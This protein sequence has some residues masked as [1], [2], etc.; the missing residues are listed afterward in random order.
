M[1]RGFTIVELLIVIVV[2]GILAAISLVTYNGI[3]DKARDA[4][5][6]AT[7]DAYEKILLIYKAQHG[8]FPQVG[9]NA[10]CLGNRDDYPARDGFAEGACYVMS[11]NGT[12]YQTESVVEPFNGELQ[13]VSSGRLPT[14]AYPPYSVNTPETEWCY[15]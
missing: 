15:I 2:I 3:Q 12:V 5:R 11:Y 13:K 9:E 4:K 8:Y 14:G 6:T 1:Q 7:V 10:Y